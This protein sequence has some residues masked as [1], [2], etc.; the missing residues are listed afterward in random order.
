MPNSLRA[1]ARPPSAV[2]VLDLQ[3]AAEDILGEVLAGLRCTPKTLPSK[4]FYDAR[5]SA[6][7]EQ[8]CAQPEYYLTR[9]ELGILQ[10]RMPAIASA[11]GE[12][13]LVLEFGSGS[14]IKT[15]RLLESLESVAG[16][17]PIDI[18]KA[19]LTASAAALRQA[20]PDLPILPICADFTQ[21]IELPDSP[22]PVRRRLMFFPGSTLGNF[23]PAAALTL[24][25]RMRSLVGPGGL[26]LLGVD[27][28]KDPARLEAAYND[29]AG[30]TAAFTLNL[31]TRLN[32]ELGADFDIGQFGHRARYHLLAGRIETHLVSRCTQKVSINGDHFV[33]R[34]AEAMLVEYSTKY[35]HSDIQRLAGQSGFRVIE[36]FSDDEGDFSLQLLQAA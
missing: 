35:A 27:M 30:I 1:R 2:Q 17:I 23:A 16:Y 25:R 36:V 14:G 31:L 8:I 4:L 13:A 24:L 10:T 21:P 9:T 3:P 26:L 20:F 11:I 15:L 7:F 29:A 19:A 6:L 32:R 12:R 33:F 18:S 22:R 5:G 28:K 34:E